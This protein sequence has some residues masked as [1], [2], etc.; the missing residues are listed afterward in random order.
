MRRPIASDRFRGMQIPCEAIFII[1][2]SYRDHARRAF[3][4]RL[5]VPKIVAIVA[6][7]AEPLFGVDE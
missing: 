7:I 2:T 4:L 3:G 5:V 1:S 6:R